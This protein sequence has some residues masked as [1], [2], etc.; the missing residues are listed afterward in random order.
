V[1]IESTLTPGLREAVRLNYEAK[2]YTDAIRDA[3]F[4]L[5]DLIRERVDLDLDGV[6][7]AHQAFGGDNPKLKI[8]K[9][10][11]VSDK[12]AQEGLHLMVW[13]L[14]LGIRNPR[15][16]D[17]HVD[18]KADADA[19]ILFV[20][21]LARLIGA[22]SPSFD[23]EEY[24]SR[25]FDVNFAVTERYATL[26]VAEIPPKKRYDLFHAVYRGMREQGKDDALRLFFRA[27]LPLLTP[28]E[29]EQA[30]AL[31]SAELATADEDGLRQNL[32]ALP[33]EEWKNYSE[34]SRLR[35][36]GALV[37]SVR[38][39]NNGATSDP[40]AFGTW[41]TRL[42]PAFTLKTE[43]VNAVCQRL[44]T[45][46][47]GPC[48]Y[49]YGY[50]LPSLPVLIEEPTPRLVVALNKRIAAG[51]RGAF[52]VATRWAG[53]EGMEA[54]TKPFA[55]AMANFKEVTATGYDDDVPF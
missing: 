50:L 5:R 11:T 54:W 29:R 34:L 27:L 43:M 38:K 14:F 35:V 8:N 44:N 31:I 24:V 30:Y 37:E 12:D 45:G 16:H 33:P 42:F 48:N 46:E 15:S 28:G 13:G 7:L 55:T 47:P 19:V 25:V 32:A 2:N 18:S 10:E 22:A 36:E 6:K 1:K 23:L 17:K 26:L 41:A 21:Y 4:Y 20:D 3:T 9:L 53:R 39:G 52:D 40:G 51:E 49:V